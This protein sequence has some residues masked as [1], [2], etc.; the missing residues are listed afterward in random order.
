[1][2]PKKEDTQDVFNKG[3]ITSM[4]RPM[5]IVTWCVADDCAEKPCLLGANCSDLVADFKCDCPTGFSGKRC[6]E[7]IDLCASNPCK[8]GV[9]VDKFFSHQCICEPG[10]TGMHKM[11]ITGQ[12][13]VQVQN[14]LLIKYTCSYIVTQCNGVWEDFD[15]I[16]TFLSSEPF[17][18]TCT[19]H[20]LEKQS[21]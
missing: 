15:N 17:I 11:V 3:D 8:H 2:R 4:F 13:I 9:C 10:W 20:V 14:N 18:Q 16:L 12:R 5:L 1:M 21:L 6:Q 19:F 7:K